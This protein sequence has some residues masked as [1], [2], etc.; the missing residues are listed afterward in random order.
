MHKKN[1]T[2]GKVEN[3]FLKPK[4]KPSHKKRNAMI[5]GGA[6]ALIFAGASVKT[7]DEK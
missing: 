1:K 6:L 5:L 2:V 4:P 7:Q 3:F